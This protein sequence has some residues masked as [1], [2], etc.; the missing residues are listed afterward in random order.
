MKNC[1]RRYIILLILMISYLDLAGQAKE[2]TLNSSNYDLNYQSTIDIQFLGIGFR[3][4]VVLG[5]KWSVGVHLGGG[6]N[7]GRWLHDFPKEKMIER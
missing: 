1:N 6:K 3:Q 2:E 7:H 5:A 4:A